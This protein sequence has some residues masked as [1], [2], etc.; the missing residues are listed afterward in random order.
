MGEIINLRRAR[1][2]KAREAAEIDATANR[3]AHGISKAELQR[4]KAA[5]LL[6]DNRLDGLRR[7]GKTDEE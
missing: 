7:T 2:R 5:R 4:G 6:L 1:K 3:S